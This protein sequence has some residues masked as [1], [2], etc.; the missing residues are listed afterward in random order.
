MELTKKISEP[1]AV[2]RNCD[3]ARTELVQ[4]RIQHWLSAI[5]R[6]GLAGSV[7]ANSTND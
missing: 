2:R 3:L 6:D 4:D 7:A 5:K 1:K